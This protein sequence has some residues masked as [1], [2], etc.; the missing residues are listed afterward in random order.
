MRFLKPVFAIL[1][2]GTTFVYANLVPGLSTK[3]LVDSAELIIVGK[4]ERVQQTGTGEITFNGVNYTRQDYVADVSVDETI[5][6][7]PVSP[8]FTLTFSA[9]SAD[10]W[11]NVAQGGLE[12]STYRVIFLNKGSSGYR[13][14]SPY[15]PSLPASPKPCGPNWE[16]VLGEDA[17]HKVLQRTLQLLCSDSTSE[18]KQSA[19]FVLNWTEDSSAA[20]FLKAAL[21]LPSVKSDPTLRI[22]IFSD[23]LHWR[24]LTV[25]PLAERDLFDQSVKSPLYPKSNLVLAISS[26]EPQI[27]VPL[28]ARVLKSPEP[29]ER[30]A[31]ARFLQY[32]NSQTA[33]DILLSALDDADRE[34][35]FAAMQSLGNLTNQH[36][37]RPTTTDTDS[38]WNA[39]IEHWHEF[40]EQRKSGAQ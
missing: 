37:W 10:R 6:G 36:Q 14:V 26:L 7:E 33:L 13:F 40:R 3:G 20:S 12:P 32:T 21:N 16:V 4:V 29:E 17:Y 18:E 35:R 2:L 24:D 23:L 5:K 30:V 22:W 34:V 9:P 1:F 28:L 8:T 27:S 15:Y 19:L 25:L 39:C 11:G 38:H 31:A